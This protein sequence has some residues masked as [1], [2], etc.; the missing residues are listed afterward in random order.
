MVK[1]SIIKWLFFWLFGLTLAVEAAN[2]ETIRVW[3]DSDK[4]R[5]VLDLNESTTFKYFTLENPNRLVIDLPAGAVNTKNIPQWPAPIKAM[6]YAQNDPQTLR[7]V[8]DLH[9]K[10]NPEVFL[11]QGEAPYGHRLVIDFPH[12]AGVTPPPVSA[13]TSAPVPAAASAPVPTPVVTQETPRIPE[14]VAKKDFIIAIDAG[15]GGQDPGAIGPSGTHEKKIVLSIANKLAALIRKEPGMKA[16]MIRDGDYFIALRERIAIARKHQADLF[17]SIH[18]DA[19]HNPRANGASVYTLSQ[20]G[21]TSEAARWLAEQENRSDLI[22]GVSLDDK[23]A[24]LASVLLDLSQTAS[25]Q[26]SVSMGSAVLKQLGGMTR[27]HSKQVQKAGFA[28][29]KSPD[30]PSILVETGFIS[31]PENE[32]NLRSEAYQNKIAEAVFTGVKEYI[33]TSHYYNDLPTLQMAATE[34]KIQRGETLSGIAERY[35]VSMVALR[36]KNKLKSDNIR[37]G[38]VLQ[39]PPG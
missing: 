29:L 6:R 15:H 24:M 8:F 7:L 13:S 21:A 36:E 33:R 37:I 32:K 18:A 12:V 4:V 26:A 11:L 34:H 27:L 5:V 3:P 2:I 30:I 38:Q 22:G 16:V 10:T 19:F 25:T 28:V 1:R 17:I 39:I 35:G 9:S 20:G 14:R 23:D 31:N